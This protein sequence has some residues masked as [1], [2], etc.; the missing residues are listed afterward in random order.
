MNEIKN[1][2]LKVV[3]NPVGAQLWSIKDE[4]NVEYLWQGDESIWSSRAPNLFPY[5][6][7]LTDGTYTL[8][9]Q[10][11]QMERHGFIRGSQ[12]VPEDVKEDGVTLVLEQNAETKKQYPYDFKYKI[13]YQLKGN[14]LHITNVVENHSNETMYFAVGGHPGFNVPFENDK[15]AKFED[16]YLEFVDECKPKLVGFT[17]DCFVNGE[18]HDYPLVDNKKINLEHGLFEIDA[19]VFEDTSKSVIIKSDTS[20]KSITVDFPQFDYVGFW[21]MAKTEAPYVCVEPWTSLPSRK[22]VVEDF[23]KQENLINVEPNGV[24]ENK[25]SITIK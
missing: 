12:L 24:Y 5:I 8:N 18:K 19:I 16:Y 7:R 13:V 10:S 21:H 17:D 20:E 11:Y 2:K 22:G 4:N 9:G 6:A 1:D 25:W 3:I 15:N 23:A 14:S